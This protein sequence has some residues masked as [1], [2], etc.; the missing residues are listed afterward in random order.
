MFVVPKLRHYLL[1]NT[2]YL[3]SQ[4]NPL[5]VLM[6]KAS[7]LND[8]LVKWSMLLSCY[9]IRYMLA[10]AIKGQALADFLAEYPLSEDQSSKMIFRMNQFCSPKRLS[11]ILLIMIFIGS[12]ISTKQCKPM[13]LEKQC[14]GWEL[15]SAIR[16]EYI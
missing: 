6:T 14:Q 1:S 10:K 16:K 12:C 4:I 8:R 11:N 5:K 3:V 13:N 9:D 7:S 2:V 15:S